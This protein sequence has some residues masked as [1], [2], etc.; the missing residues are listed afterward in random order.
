MNDITLQNSEDAMNARGPSILCPIDFSEQSRGALTY[1]AAIAD[2]FGARLI[3]LTVDDPLLADAAEAAGIEPSL[4]SETGAELQR[5]CAEVF[6]HRGAGPRSIDYRVATGKPAI[7]ILREASE[8]KADLIVISSRGRSGIRKMFFGSTTER[9][10][11]E[12]P[13]PVLI[14]PGD[15]APVTSLADIARHINRVLAPIDLSAGSLHQLAIANGIAKA[16]SVPLLIAHVVEP[17][18]VPPTVRQ[19]MHGVEVARI[20]RAHERVAELAASIATNPESIVRTGEAAEEIVALADARHA[21]LIV[22]GLHSSGLL[23]ARMGAVT[24]RVL[25]LSHSLVFAIPPALSPAHGAHVQHD[26]G[27]VVGSPAR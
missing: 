23:G 4:A 1:A 24:Y 14:T 22:M 17:V 9:V 15:R 21:N 18:F 3:V 26:A 2:H 5:F 6:A 11:R 20:A 12:T 16:L 8:Q 7:E 19:A 25:C 10:L 27:A 13:V